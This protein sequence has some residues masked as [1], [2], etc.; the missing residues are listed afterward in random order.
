MEGHFKAIQF[1]IEERS[2]DPA[3]RDFSDVIWRPKDNFT[4]NIFHK[5]IQ[6]TNLSYANSVPTYCLVHAENKESLKLKTWV[7]AAT[8]CISEFYLVTLATIFWS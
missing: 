3:I 7:V 4:I 5:I 2:F 6:P 8:L 1:F